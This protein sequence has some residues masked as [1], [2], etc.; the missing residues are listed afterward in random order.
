MKTFLLDQTI[1]DLCKDANGNIAVA[2]EPYAIAQDVGSE[3]RVFYGEVFYD[4][5]RGID[6]FE[7]VLGYRPPLAALRAQYVAAALTV[8]GVIE[9]QCFFDGLA[10]R[11]LTG[12]IQVRDD[13]GDVQ[14][15]G[16]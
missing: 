13:T 16:F 3:C 6:Y 14:I 1:W 9:A 10:G 12:Q 5:T 8:P 15:V 4:T 7:D 2:S 11:K